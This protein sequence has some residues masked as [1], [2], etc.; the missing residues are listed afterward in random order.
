MPSMLT[1]ALSWP[2]LVF[3]FATWAV[4]LAGIACLQHNCNDGTTG[5]GTS[6]V[7]TPAAANTFGSSGL[8]GFSS[9]LPCARFFRFWWFVM[10]FEFVTLVGAFIAAAPKYGLASSRPFW[11]DDRGD[12]FWG[13]GWKGRTPP[14]ATNNTLSPPTTTKTKTQPQTNPKPQKDRHVFDLH[15]AVHDCVRGVLSRA[16]RAAV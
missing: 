14:K 3:T 2:A 16:R 13:G 11:C 1:R 15:A 9:A 5:A 6:Q 10:A 8:F 4:F 12:G 7:P